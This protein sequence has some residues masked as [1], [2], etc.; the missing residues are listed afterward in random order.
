MSRSTLSLTPHS[1]ME[2]AFSV[3]IPPGTPPGDYFA[4]VVVAEAGGPRQPNGLVVTSRAALIVQVTVPGVAH[5]AVHLGPLRVRRRGHTEV[6]SVDVVD[7]GNTLAELSGD[8]DIHT[9]FGHTRLDLGPAGA[10]VIPGGTATLTATWQ[11]LPVIGV[12]HLAALVTATT[13][14]HPPLVLRS[15]TVGRWFVPWRL[16]ALVIVLIALVVVGW[17]RTR[18]WRGRRADERRVVKEYRA[19]RVGSAEP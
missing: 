14:G 10:Y 13:P 3:A 2:D 5:V 18:G 9:T 1:Q 12:A 7:Q 16:V 15:A 11:G 8:V 19:G 4:A 17:R 6:L